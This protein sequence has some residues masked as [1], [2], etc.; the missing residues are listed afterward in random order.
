MRIESIESLRQHLRALQARPVHEQRILRLWSQ[1]LPQDSGRRRLEDF[2]PQPLREAL[3]GIEQ[4]L[5]MVVQ[6][7]GLQ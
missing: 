7:L 1:A 5:L 4:A 6:T 3:P 2:M